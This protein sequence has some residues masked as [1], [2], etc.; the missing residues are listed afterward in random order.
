VRANNSF[1]PPSVTI[2]L[3]DTVVW[4]RTG[5]FHNVRADDGSF[6]LGEGA[7][8]NPGSSWTTGSHTF[9]TAGSFRYF[10]EV[11]GAAGGSGMSG[12]VIVQDTA[13]TQTPTATNPSPT[14]TATATLVPTTTAP[15][16][17]YMPVIT[18]S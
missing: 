15:S 10:C 7:A 9:T 16:K 1:F 5:G 11:H 2:A 4:Q 14:A 3:G 12:I 17:V 8:G 6:R 18:K 13:V